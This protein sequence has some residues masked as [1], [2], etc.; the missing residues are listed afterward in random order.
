M[1]ILIS[2]LKSLTMICIAAMIMI[3]SLKSPAQARYQQTVSGVERVMDILETFE[4]I[5]DDDEDDD[6][7]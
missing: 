3:A 7:D 2:T 5:G 1:T 6:D 4:E